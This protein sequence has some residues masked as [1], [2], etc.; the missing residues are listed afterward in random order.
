MTPPLVPPAGDPG[1]LGFGAVVA[2]ARGRRLLNRDGTF[3]TRRRGLGWWQSQ[4]LYHLALAASWPRFLWALAAAFAACNVVFALLFLLCG[5]DALTGAPAHELGGH[6]WRAFFFSVETFATIGYGEISPVGVVP[7]ALVVGESLVAL[8]L[9]A[10]ATGLVFARF[11]RPSAALRFSDQALVAPFRDGRA[12]MFRLVNTRQNELVDLQVRVIFSA[13]DGSSRGLGR[14]F[15]PLVLERDQVALLP[16][17][18][19]V[20]HPITPDSPLWGL[21]DATLRARDAELL[22]MGAGLDDTF[23]QQV[24]TRT[25]Y[26]AEEVV[27]GARFVNI[28][29]PPEPDGRMSID[30]RRL[31]TWEPADLP[32][33][34]PPTP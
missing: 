5:P 9:Q 6:F 19:T 1:D 24:H 4:E 21:D 18:W 23:Q 3:N 14:Q 15:T 33:T 2:G 31:S 22:V 11:A 34:A 25:S 27:W 32:A 8:V 20:V 12:L 26:R 16:L 28:F 17:S 29:E 13:R 10:V 30:V 7:H